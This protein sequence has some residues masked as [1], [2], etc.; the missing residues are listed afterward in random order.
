MARSGCRAGDKREKEQPGLGTLGA[1]LARVTVISKKQSIHAVGAHWSHRSMARLRKRT[2]ESENW[3]GGP[4]AAAQFHDNS[5][6]R[7]QMWIL[8]WSDTIRRRSCAIPAPFLAPTEI[9]L[10]PYTT[11]SVQRRS[12]GH[13]KDLETGDYANI[14]LLHG[15]PNEEVHD[16]SGVLCRTPSRIAS[17]RRGAP[18]T[19]YKYIRVAEPS[20]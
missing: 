17:A 13:D 4:D 1:L 2:M 12:K 11:D 10:I 3:L 8:P 16:A 18:E 20:E 6:P 7:V 5:S 19:S 9:R 15:G 14:G